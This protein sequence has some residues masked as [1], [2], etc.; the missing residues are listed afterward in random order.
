[1][2]S[3][4]TGTISH[5]TITATATVTQQ[6]NGNSNSES[7]SA[8]AASSTVGTHPLY[9]S[10]SSSSSGSSR[11]KSGLSTGAKA[12]IGAG[13]GG[14]VLGI[15][16]VVIAIIWRNRNRNRNRPQQVPQDMPEIPDQGGQRT[17]WVEYKSELDANQHH[18]QQPDHNTQ[19]SKTAAYESPPADPASVLSRPWNELHADPVY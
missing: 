2:S 10:S 6:A 11:R 7:N 18:H 17:S 4:A 8:S 19:V 13:V 14:G 12:G 15:L 1:L 9:S 3:A 5:D 16:G